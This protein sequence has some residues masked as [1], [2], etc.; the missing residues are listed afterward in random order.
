M[1]QEIL[2]MFAWNKLEHDGKSAHPP[3]ADLFKHVVPI[4][5]RHFGVSGVHG[6]D[7]CLR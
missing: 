5:H 2:E 6:V 4:Q 7:A 3:G 1:A